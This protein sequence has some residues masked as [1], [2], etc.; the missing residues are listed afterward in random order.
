MFTIADKLGA[1]HDEGIVS[2]QG[3]PNV[4][5]PAVELNAVDVIAVPMYA[6]NPDVVDHV[7]PAD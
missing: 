5:F 3:V 2:E 7:I 6:T 1:V 4:R